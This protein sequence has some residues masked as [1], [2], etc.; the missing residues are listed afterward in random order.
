MDADE[1][2]ATEHTGRKVNR[3]GGAVED[4]VNDVQQIAY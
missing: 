4:S 1:I 2:A 3:G